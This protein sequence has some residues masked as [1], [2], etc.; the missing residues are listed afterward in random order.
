MLFPWKDMSKVSHPANVESSLMT[1]SNY[2][3]KTTNIISCHEDKEEKCLSNSLVVFWPACSLSP[4]KSV[5]WPFVGCLILNIPG[6]LE[7]KKVEIFDFKN[8]N[9]QIEFKKLTTDTTDFSE[10][11]TNDLPFEDQ[12][13]NWKKVLY[14][15]FQKS[16]SVSY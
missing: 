4:Q 6:R 12:S 2:T 7:P 15:Y 8:K 11:F 3:R 16:F 13:L 14:N 10:C 1:A 9:S 5:Y